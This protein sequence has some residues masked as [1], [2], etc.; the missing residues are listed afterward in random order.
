MLARQVES[1]SVAAGTPPEELQSFARALAHDV[2]PIPTLPNIEVERVRLLARPVDPPGGGGGGL[3]PGGSAPVDCP[4]RPGSTADWEPSAG[5][6][7][8]GG[9]PP[10]PAGRTSSVA[11]AEIGG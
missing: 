10:E 5:E 8:T 3:A 1:F 4:P 6:A 9:T 11:V 7:T 2:T